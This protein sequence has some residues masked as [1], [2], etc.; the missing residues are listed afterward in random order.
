LKT[1]ATWLTF[2]GL[3]RVSSPIFKFQNWLRELNFGTPD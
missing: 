2:L 1:S 3:R